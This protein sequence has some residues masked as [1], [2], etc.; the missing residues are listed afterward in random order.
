MRGCSRPFFWAYC[1]AERA[2]VVALC[3]GCSCPASVGRTHRRT[4]VRAAGRRA[5]RASASRVGRRG[6]A[7]AMIAWTGSKVSAS[8]SGSWVSSAD[9]I[10][11]SLVVPAHAWC[12]GRG[13][14]RR[15][16]GG[17]RPCVACSRPG[18]RCSG[19]CARMARTA[20]LAHAPPEC[21]AVPVA[22]RG[23]GRTGRAMPSA[24]RPSAMRSET[25]AV[26]VLGEDPSHDRGG[27]RGRARGGGARCPS[28]ALAGFGWGPA[29]ASW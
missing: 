2:P 6:R 17:P 23:R 28:A 5:R 20:D 8:M 11:S 27:D 9:Q 21:C 16:R 13:R 7:A 12:R 25:V 24:V 10:Q 15:R 22:V 19:G 3:R 14:R 29:S 18:G 1:V 26:E 4:A